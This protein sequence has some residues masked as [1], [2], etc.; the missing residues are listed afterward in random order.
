VPRLTLVTCTGP[1]DDKYKTY[2]DR[3]VLEA[4]YAGVG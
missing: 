4:T 2:K 1:F 3:L